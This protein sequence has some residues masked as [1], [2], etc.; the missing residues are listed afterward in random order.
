M[1]KMKKKNSKKYSFSK[2]KVIFFPFSKPKEVDLESEN[3]FFLGK[4]EG[5]FGLFGEEEK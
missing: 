1:K 2:S 5:N 4:K 3:K